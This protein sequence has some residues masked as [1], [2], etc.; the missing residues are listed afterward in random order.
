MITLRKLLYSI[1][2][3]TSYPFP[4]TSLHCTWQE[5]DRVLCHSSLIGSQELDEAIELL[6]TNFNPRYTDSNNENFY[7]YMISQ[8]SAYIEDL[9]E[10]HS[11][12]DALAEIERLGK[13]W[14]IINDV[15]Y[16]KK[17]AHASNALYKAGCTNYDIVYGYPFINIKGANAI[18]PM[19][20]HLSH[21]L[22]RSIDNGNLT[23]ESACDPYIASIVHEILHA[24][25]EKDELEDKKDSTQKQEDKTNTTETSSDEQSSETT[26][27]T[28]NLLIPPSSIN[29]E[30]DDTEKFHF[31]NQMRAVNDVLTSIVG[32]FISALKQSFIEYVYPFPE[33]IKRLLDLYITISDRHTLS[34]NVGVLLVTYFK[35][36]IAFV[37]PDLIQLEDFGHWFSHLALPEGIPTDILQ[38]YDLHPNTVI[39][40][41]RDFDTPDAVL[42]IINN[43]RNFDPLVHYPDTKRTALMQ[44]I[45]KFGVPPVKLYHDPSLRDSEGNTAQD[46]WILYID[47]DGK[48]IPNEIRY[49]Y[50]NR[51]KLGCTH[52][53]KYEY[54]I[55]NRIYCE[56][57]AESKL[58]EDFKDK[59][60]REPTSDELISAKSSA[61]A[62]I[63]ETEECPICYEPYA[64]EK[65]VIFPECRHVICM[66]CAN[67]SIYCPY[68]RK[69]HTMKANQE[70]SSELSAQEHERSLNE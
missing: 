57:C 49:A 26:S 31:E 34:H 62:H 41:I 33:F 28:P 66:D 67:R 9:C 13:K 30:A 2:D 19:V 38:N 56:E 39:N 3:P 53:E 12:Q 68:C 60:N 69:D 37:L 7:Q 58:K 40:A 47:H 29:T 32:I 46:L 65:Y 44:Y 48:D 1:E 20:A 17:Y 27:F 6:K 51:L 45:V 16:L 55:G 22:L 8:I 64:P 36:N 54:V 15:S 14:L 24:A 18:Y 43:M 35:Y 61:R 59:N 11:L 63:L 70:Q 42:S 10:I 23:F 50:Y 21:T 25:I 5:I 4:E 52:T